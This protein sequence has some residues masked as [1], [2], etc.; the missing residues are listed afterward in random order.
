MGV[1][2]IANSDGEGALLQPSHEAAVRRYFQR[3]VPVHD[4]DDLVQDVFLSIRQRRQGGEI[5]NVDAYLFT[6]AAHALSRYR[7][8]AAQLRDDDGAMAALAQIEDPS[9]PERALMGRE[10]IAVVVR[11]LERLPARTREIFMMHRFSAMTYA[12]IARHHGISPSAIEKHM[13]TALRALMAATE[14][15]R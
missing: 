3:R 10:E 5:E 6:V 9:T 11:T 1:N 7:R 12:A 2:A 14:R 13:T 4:V 15:T 8:K